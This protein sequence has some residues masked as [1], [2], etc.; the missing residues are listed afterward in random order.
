M[1]PCEPKMIEPGRGSSNA[2]KRFPSS[3]C[4]SSSKRWKREEA[5]MAE[6][7]PR[8]SVRVFTDVMVGG[9]PDGA[10]A[11]GERCASSNASPARNLAGYV[12]GVVLNSL[13]P[14]SQNP[15]K[16]QNVILTRSAQTRTQRHTCLKVRCNG[17]GHW[18]PIMDNLSN[19]GTHCPVAEAW[20]RSPRQTP[21]YE[22]IR[23]TTSDI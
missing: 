10:G 15:V 2:A 21:R 4:F 14:R 5:W 11:V 6:M 8:S 22:L 9:G 23:T 1:P 16:R 19:L 20:V 12:S 17:L 3:S 13:C 18:P 7:C